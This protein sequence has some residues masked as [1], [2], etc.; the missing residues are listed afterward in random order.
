[1]IFIEY[2]LVVANLLFFYDR[3]LH[4]SLLHWATWKALDFLSVAENFL[5]QK[6]KRRKSQSPRKSPSSEVLMKWL[7]CFRSS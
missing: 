2:L 5:Q 7:I 1:M 3:E 6:L 4:Y